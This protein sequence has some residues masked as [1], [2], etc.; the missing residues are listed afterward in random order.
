MAG[1]PV[2]LPI[3]ADGRSATRYVDL[4]L[5][6]LVESATRGRVRG[7]DLCND[8]PMFADGRCWFG[9]HGAALGH[10]L[11]RGVGSGDVFLFFGLF[12]EP[13]TGERH[14]RIFSYL[15]VES[16][17]D[18]CSIETPRPHPHAIG[19]WGR[20]NLLFVGAGAT[21]AVASADLRLTKPG[22]PLRHW[23]VPDWL[24]RHGLSYHERAER[25]LSDGILEAASRGQEFVTDVG[26]D[27]AALD[28][29]AAVIAAIR[30]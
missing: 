25:W 22:G 5:G 4:G 28:W 2:S 12:G 13:A 20:R 17:A 29:L 10:L 9:Q 16:V 30:G 21:A 18:P 24:A 15:R 3:P 1:R 26:E 6:D 8:D 23:Q 7:R 19:D 11:N 27:P 14:H